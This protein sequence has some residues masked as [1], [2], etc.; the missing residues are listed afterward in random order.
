MPCVRYSVT[1]GHK[2]AGVGSTTTPSMLDLQLLCV[3]ACAVCDVENMD[4]TCCCRVPRVL[5][6]LILLCL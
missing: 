3:P 1:A 4:V 5:R 6:S 2:A